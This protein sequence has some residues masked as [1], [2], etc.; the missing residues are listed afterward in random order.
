M[1][2][3]VLI[4][5]AGQAGLALSH[6][7]RRRGVDHVLLE[8][9]AVGQRWRDRRQASLTL[10]TPNWMNLLPGSPPHAEPDGFLA[11]DA[12]IAYLEDYARDAPVLSGVDVQA[13]RPRRGGGFTVQADRGWW[14]ARQVVLATGDC[15]VPLRPAV[16]TAAPGGLMPLTADAYVSPEALPAGAILVVG[17]GPSGQQIALELARAGRDVTLAVGRHA[18]GVRTW[19][20]RDIWWWLE[21]TGDLHRP[22]GELRDARAAA[23]SPSLPLSGRGPLDLGVLHA[24]GVRLAGRLT[25]FAGGAA[26]FD[27]GLPARAAEADRRLRRILAKLEAWRSADDVDAAALDADEPAPLALPPGPA[28][29]PLRRSGAAAIIWATG[30]RRADPPAPP[31]V[32]LLGAKFLRR[33]SSHLL[34][35]VGRDAA[36]LAA[37]LAHPRRGATASL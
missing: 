9:G 24:A 25:G 20:G 31:G 37:E 6:H 32:P 14:R 21:Q 26:Q 34:G 7:L 17:A 35:G 15:A 28:E 22:V 36:E 8:R 2:T 33:R 10:L 19:R 30:Y 13:V 12:L 4:V 1:D 3:E 11:R 5:G 27:D 16:A 29:L 18:R 23:A